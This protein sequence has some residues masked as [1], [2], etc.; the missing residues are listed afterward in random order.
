MQGELVRVLE[1]VVTRIA[2]DPW[3]AFAIVSLLRLILRRRGW[4]RQ[5]RQAPSDRPGRLFVALPMGLVQRE[6]AMH[7]RRKGS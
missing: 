2:K 6:A 5:K 7:E 1:P 4:A 3:R